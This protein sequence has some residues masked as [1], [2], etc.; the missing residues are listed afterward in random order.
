MAKIIDNVA[1]RDGVFKRVGYEPHRGQRSI[2][3]STARHRVAACGR[4]FGKSF[5]GG[6]ELTVEAFRARLILPSLEQSGKRREFWIVGPNYTDA[7]KEF[8][9]MYDGLAK[10][11]APFDKPGTYNNP[12][13]GDMQVSLYK[14]KF[15]VIAKSAQ[16]PE[17]L[18]GEGLNGVI[19]AEAAKQK[20]ST[21]NKYIRPMLA[22]YN[23]WSLH[24]STPE[25]KNWFYDAWMR[26]QSQ[27]E[28]DWES[29]RMPSWRNPYVYPHGATKAAVTS[30][31]RAIDSKTT[32]I[33]SDMMLAMGVDP[34]VGALMKDLTQES[35]GAEIAA[36]FTE[37][38]GRVF[39]DFDEEL[40]VKDFN[41]RPDWPIY[42]AA[43][44]GF[45]NPFVWLL[46]QISPD[47]TVWVLDEM[48]E[49][50]LT[51]DEAGDEI[52]ARGLCPSSVKLLY[53]DPA[54]PGDTRALEKK[55]HIRGMRGTGGLLSVRLR[56]I[57]A[58]LKERNTHLPYGSAERQPKMFINRR[59]IETIREFS[60]YRYPQTV[61][62]AADR[63]KEP[64]E[65]PMKVD[66]HT[67]ETLGRFFAGHFGVPDA[68]R[69]RRGARQATADVS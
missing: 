69:E 58:A 13:D 40:H 16:Y 5:L 1:L 22:D 52:L 10:L 26:G 25:G 23:G 24:T 35:F 56:Y 21:W 43:D 2:H 47:G 14:G 65:N 33:T 8:R 6:E 63:G 11:G 42:A 68:G 9:V 67:P 27:F 44:Y 36:E 54:S 59:C 57:R 28:T 51:I 66:D 49:R 41:Y 53:P 20:P 50:G 34:E 29:W 31:R 62:E 18:V 3:T 19:M 45:T 15:V 64:S 30:L 32:A 61:A 17:R 39:K 12:H 55:L 60:A 46:I 7:E 48:Y 37:F 4:R 38:V